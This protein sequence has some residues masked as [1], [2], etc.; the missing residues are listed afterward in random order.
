MHQSIG[1]KN[2]VAIYLIFL[3]ILST[4]SGKF[5]AQNTNYLLKID[6]IDVIGL[7]NI[8]NLQIQ[9]DLSSIFYQNIFTLE[10]KKINKIVMK[11]NII[12]KYSI[13]K[14]YPSTL[15]IKIKPTEF[16]A[17]LADDNQSIVGSNGKLISSE[18]GN[19]V[20]PHILGEF[21]SK[22]FLKFKSNVKLSKF[23]FTEFENIYFFPSHR[24]D[25][26]TKNNILIKLSKNHIV[27][28]LN[29]AHKIITSTEFK[30]KNVI[31]LRI[32]NHLIIK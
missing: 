3:F 11:H 10:K 25:I 1:K 23:N 2:N 22:E 16:L 29:M 17:K 20:L 31:D 8:K 26:L 15:K 5:S 4:T 24:W 19:K 32:K 13:K 12:D 30:N 28:S 6:K 21:N 14:I 9:K 7:S 18:L 27:E